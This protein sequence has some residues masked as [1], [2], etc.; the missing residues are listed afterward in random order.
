M[1]DKYLKTLDFG[2]GDK[3]HMLPLV[4]SE[5]DGMLLRVTNGEWG[6]GYIIPPPPKSK[7]YIVK[8]D[9]NNP[10]PL[11]CCTYD[12]DAVGMGKG[13]DEWDTIFGYKPCIMEDGVV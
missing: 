6:A 4:T 10:D 11:D 7:T 2:N 3:Y 8:I 5:N 12:G 13:S 1:A 9:Q